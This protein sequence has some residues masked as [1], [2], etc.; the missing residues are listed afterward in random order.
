MSLDEFFA[1][2]LPLTGRMRRNLGVGSTLCRAVVF[3]LGIAAITGG[4]AKRADE[5]VPSYA[6]DITDVGG[7]CAVFDRMRS[8][9]AERLIFASIAQNQVA[10]EDRER[11]FGMTP[12][13]F[14]TLFRGDRAEEV[15]DLKTRIAEIDL[16]RS[17]YGCVP[18]WN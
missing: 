10:R 4:C 18:I 14:G 6:S 16:Q 9:A 15:A 11:L 2:S 7:N 1:R 13:M 5:I 12:S 8:R 17:L 3:V